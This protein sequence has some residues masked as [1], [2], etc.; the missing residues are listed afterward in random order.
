[1]T[2]NK[3]CIRCRSKTL[4]ENDFGIDR[5]GDYLKTC[6][7]CREHE[8]QRKANTREYTNEKAREHYQEVREDKIKQ[9][10]KWKAENIDRLTEKIEC[11]CGGK[12]QFMQK[13]EHGRTQKHQK[14]M[15]SLTII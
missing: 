1:M 12:F 3:K 9:V 8:K 11:A 7:N 5:H 6:N 10:L 4:T 2:E 15:S 13:A 14:Y